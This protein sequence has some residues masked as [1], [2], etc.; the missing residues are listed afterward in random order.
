M[1]RCAPDPRALGW[2]LI[3]L[4]LGSSAGA[5][6]GLMS[7]IWGQAAAMMGVL[8]LI[9]MVLVNSCDGDLL[10]R[11]YRNLVVG[12]ALAGLLCGAMAASPWWGILGGGLGP[13]ALLLLL[14]A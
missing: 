9:P 7:L 3:M 10:G 12:A 14:L 4:A 2:T 8:L 6:G 11:A 13:A 5:L 1:Q